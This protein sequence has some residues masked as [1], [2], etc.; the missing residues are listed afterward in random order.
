[1]LSDNQIQPESDYLAMEMNSPQE[2]NSRF[3]EVRHKNSRPR[4]QSNNQQRLLNSKN[5]VKKT[6]TQQDVSETRQNNLRLLIPSS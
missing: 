5:K 4:N 6:S 2:D 1:M 3:Q